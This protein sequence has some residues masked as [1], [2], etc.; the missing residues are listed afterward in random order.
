MFGSLGEWYVSVMLTLKQKL[1]S[2][3]ILKVYPRMIN[4]YLKAWYITI[5]LSVTLRI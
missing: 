1:K 5:D 4:N 3:C 2:K